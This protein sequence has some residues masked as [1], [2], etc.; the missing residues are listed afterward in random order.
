MRGY[1]HG[2][3]VGAVRANGG[4]QGKVKGRGHSETWGKGPEAMQSDD[5]SFF[6]QSRGLAR[7]VAVDDKTTGKSR[8]ERNGLAVES[9]TSGR[10]QGKEVRYTS[11]VCDCT[12]NGELMGGRVRARGLT[13]PRSTACCLRSSAAVRGENAPLSCSCCCFCTCFLM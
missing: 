9:H 11:R 5:A 1:V 4:A 7:C 13:I 8:Q 3:L 10:R 12:L 6:F 2:L